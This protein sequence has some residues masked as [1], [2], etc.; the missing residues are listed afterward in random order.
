ML[1]AGKLSLKRHVSGSSVP[2][3]PKPSEPQWPSRA[4]VPSRQPGSTGAFAWL[5]LQRQHPRYQQQFLYPLSHISSETSSSSPSSISWL[6][7]CDHRATF[8]I[9]LV[10]LCECCGNCI[11]EKSNSRVLGSCINMNLVLTVCK[12]VEL[13]AWPVA[14]SLSNSNSVPLPTIRL[15]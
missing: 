1:Q 15:V 8:L 11:A 3:G 14:F 13:Q 12:V 9:F 7:Y 2:K 5:G 4:K 10:P 6:H